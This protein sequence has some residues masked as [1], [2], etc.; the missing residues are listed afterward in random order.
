MSAN[1]MLPYH[2]LLM[3]APTLGA[4]RCLFAL[5]CSSFDAS[6]TFADYVYL[7]SRK[8][9]EEIVM[10]GKQLSKPYARGTYKIR[11]QVLA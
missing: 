7:L 3:S 1:S 4:V 9:T 2:L 5:L 8:H 6:F 10:T 11:G